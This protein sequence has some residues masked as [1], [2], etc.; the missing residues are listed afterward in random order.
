MLTAHAEPRVNRPR[1]S[2]GGDPMPLHAELVPRPVRGVA[3]PVLR[4]R[5]GAPPAIALRGR[6]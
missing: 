4:H 5:A 6:L 3:A 1:G 2:R